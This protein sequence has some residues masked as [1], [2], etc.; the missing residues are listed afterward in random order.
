[1]Y[2]IGPDVGLEALSNRAIDYTLLP[3]RWR[4]IYTTAPDVRPLLIADRPAPFQVGNIYQQFSDVEQGDV[5]NIIEFSIPMLLQKGTVEVR[6]KYD[7]R[8]PQRIRL[9]F[10]EAG[11]RNLSITDEL[12]L[13]LAPAI[14]PRSWLNHQVLLALREAEVFVPLRARLP[15][16]FQSASTSLERNFGSDYLL[17]YLDDD[18][19]IGSQTGSGGTFIFVRD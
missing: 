16:L 9:M 15:A 14:L 6:A 10:Q 2:V 4:L 7:I 19:L 17:T 18:T 12:E 8:S 11:V 5:Q 13:L 1:M 3:G